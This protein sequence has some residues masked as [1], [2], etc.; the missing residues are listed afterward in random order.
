MKMKREQGED[1]GKEPEQF[2][3]LFIGG[4]DYRTTDDSL[5]KHFEQWGDIVDVVV[6]K[7]PT[8]KRSRGFGFITYSRAHMVDDAQ[9][10]RPHRVDG[11]VVEPKRA[12]PRQDIGRPEAGATVKKLFVGGL[13]DDVEDEDLREHFKVFGTIL[14]VTVVTDKDTGKKRGFGFIEF[15]DYDSVDKICLQRHHT[16]KG[17]HIDVKKA[18]S[19][20]EMDRATSGGPSGGGG[21]GPRG[22]RGGPRG[23]Q[24]GSGNWNRG[25][26]GD[27]S[28]SRPQSQGGYNGGAWTSS[29]WDNQQ[30]SNW[31]GP[32]AP[33]GGGY[34]TG[35]SDW[36]QGGG[37]GNYQ[38]GYG[39]G[40]VRNNYHQNRSAP[41]GNPS[42]GGGYNQS[43]NMGS[44]NMG[45]NRRF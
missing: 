40:A 9:N 1:D 4:L 18:L 28:G 43:G 6:M 7:D 2:R 35:P 41:Y 15:E 37:F 33:A 29:P 23:G 3:K 45:A 8:T 12:V 27:W 39:G 32:N 36:N 14:S 25:P 24:G 20:A 5:K 26:A 38:Q 21:G 16:I 34:N 10:A 19:K 11:R 17:K 13:K 44:G 42:Y 31:G 30:Q 22:G